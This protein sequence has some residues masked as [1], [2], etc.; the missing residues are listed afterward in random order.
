[1]PA[2]G[3]GCQG[4]ATGKHWIL[5]ASS[6][7]GRVPQY[8]SAALVCTFPLLAGWLAGY[9]NE[10][11]NPFGL[12]SFP[13]LP[14][15]SRGRC[16]STPW[17]VRGPHQ[18][19]ASRLLRGEGWLV[20]SCSV[21][22]TS[23]C[24]ALALTRTHSGPLWPDIMI[25]SWSF[26]AVCT[27]GPSNNLT[28]LIRWTL[29]V[30]VHQFNWLFIFWFYCKKLSDLLTVLCLWCMESCTCALYFFQ[31]HSSRNSSQNRILCFALTWVLLKSH[32]SGPQGTSFFSF[33][34]CVNSSES[35]EEGA[36][37]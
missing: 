22:G 18:L 12:S 36:K 34:L 14:P 28:W 11:M 15:H 37:M 23:T 3:S 35:C 9:L 8:V 13:S 10:I 31:A 4:L 25:L 32:S 17:S 26:R 24:H 16:S 7:R 27:H 30:L 29:S 2:A 21:F 19:P 6:R 5:L 1:M 20:S 33:S